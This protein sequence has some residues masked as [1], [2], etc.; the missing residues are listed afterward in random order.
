MI[1]RP[2]RST[3]FPYTTLFRSVREARAKAQSSRARAM[4]RV[5][6]PF[7]AAG[8]HAGDRG[9]RFPVEI[10]AHL[11]RRAAARRMAESARQARRL[12][13]GRP[14]GGGLQ[15]RRTRGALL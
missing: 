15:P 6:A 1:R 9:A 11:R 2:P 12:A 4:A 10:R 13:G 14:P 3:L 7:P 8:G 5:L